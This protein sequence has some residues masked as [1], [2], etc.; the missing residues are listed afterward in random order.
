MP[1]CL[2]V[3]HFLDRPG[4]LGVAVELAREHPGVPR[5]DAPRHLDRGGA[6]RVIGQCAGTVARE[7]GAGVRDLTARCGDRKG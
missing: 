1:L 2:P 7:G 6:N 5:R 3:M 4:Q